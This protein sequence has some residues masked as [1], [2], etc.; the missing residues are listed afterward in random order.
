MHNHQAVSLEEWRQL[1]ALQDKEYEE[2]LL[3]DRQKDDDAKKKMVMLQICF[4]HNIS[5]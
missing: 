2:S 5:I 3:I 1:R 4:F